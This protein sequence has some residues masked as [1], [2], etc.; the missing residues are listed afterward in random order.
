M[1]FAQSLLNQL[2]NQS[3]GEIKLSRSTHKMRGVMR[4]AWSV[5]KGALVKDSS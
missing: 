2:M 3:Y 4:G 5:L 1:S